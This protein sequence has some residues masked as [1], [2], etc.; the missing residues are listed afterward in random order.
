[1][2]SSGGCEIQ[3]C[4]AVGRTGL[5]KSESCLGGVRCD[6]GRA[7]Y[8]SCLGRVYKAAA[9]SENRLFLY[10]TGPQTKEENFNCKNA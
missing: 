1:M 8:R 3:F 7:L 10:N 4:R 6:R 5:F 9:A 2:S